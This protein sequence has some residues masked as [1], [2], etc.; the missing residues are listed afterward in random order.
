MKTFSQFTAELDEELT[1]HQRMIKKA[2]KA[3]DNAMGPVT[4]RKHLNS[5]RHPHP[6]KGDHKSFDKGVAAAT[7]ARSRVLDAQIK[8]AQAG[9]KNKPHTAG[10]VNKL[11][12]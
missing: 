10:P 2:V 7:T 11:P 12:K 4:A 6:Q 9:R 8:I 5:V 3:V 1:R